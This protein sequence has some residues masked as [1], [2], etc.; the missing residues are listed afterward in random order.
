M[1]FILKKNGVYRI[2]DDKLDLIAKVNMTSTVFLRYY[3]CCFWWIK[4]KV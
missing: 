4:K 3:Y 1:E 2:E